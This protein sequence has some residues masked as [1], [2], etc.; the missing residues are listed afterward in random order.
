M[1]LV[2]HENRPVAALLLTVPLMTVGT[3]FLMVLA[4]GTAQGYGVSL[5]CRLGLVVIPL[6]W[7]LRV[8]RGRLSWSPP[9]RGGF[10]VAALLGLL[11]G[12]A[13]LG[14]YWICAAG[15]WIDPAPLR[16]KAAQ[17]G[18]DRLGVYL[19]GAV[20]W[21]TLNSLA[22]EYAWR[23]FIFRQFEKLLPGPAAVVASALGFTAHH[24]IPLA[25]YFHWLL[26]LLASVG[27][28]IGGLAWSWLYLRYRSVWPAY[29]SHAMVDLP[30]F[31]V[32]YLLIFG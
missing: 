20:Y 9:A 26:A 23:W 16:A 18:L 24:V 22:E 15:T 2:T 29:L 12:G 28:F 14:A 3:L 7:H 32:G 6:W 10:G 4:P 31:V 17:V 25:I 27:V 21:I 19:A 13:I 1:K 30:I 8:D 5:V 11:L